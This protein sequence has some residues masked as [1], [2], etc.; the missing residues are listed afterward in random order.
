M[1]GWVVVFGVLYWC[2]FGKF[3]VVVDFVVC[4]LVLVFV[5]GGD[6]GDGGGVGCV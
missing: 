3:V 4:W 6:I 1:G 2:Y 5:D